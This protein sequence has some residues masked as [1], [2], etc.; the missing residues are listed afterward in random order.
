[1]ERQLLEAQN[2]AVQLRGRLHQVEQARSA[3]ENAR[4]ESA[5]RV[6][7]LEQSV[8][9]RD[10][11]LRE[12]AERCSLRLQQIKAV[13]TTY[14]SDDFETDRE[15][16]VVDGVKCLVQTLRDQSAVCRFLHCHPIIIVLLLTHV[17][18][19]H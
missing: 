18:A 7:E 14:V 2:E 5:A 16:D 17:I 10:E 19:T 8:H 3:A 11:Q 9:C 6:V 1:L 4:D 12:D 15:A 13:L